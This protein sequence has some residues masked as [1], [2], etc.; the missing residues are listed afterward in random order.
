MN[1]LLLSCKIATELIEKKSVV[2]L[3]FRETLQLKLHN[4]VC[5]VC[6]TYQ[7]QSIILDAK[8]LNYFNN[9]HS[10]KIKLIINSELKQRILKNLS[11]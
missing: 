6:N 3:T 4:S 11:S 10:N 7:K 1:K 8:L 5:D 2:P 9:V